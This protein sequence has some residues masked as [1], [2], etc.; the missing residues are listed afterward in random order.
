[1]HVAVYG[2]LRRGQS[3][4]SVLSRHNPTLLG[5]TVIHGYAMYNVGGFPAI[6]PDDEASTVVVELYDVT[7]DAL[8]GLDSLEGYRPGN[9]EMSLYLRQQIS[10]Q[11]IHPYIYVWNGSI[12]G[13]A[14]LS[15]DWL[16]RNERV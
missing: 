13:P 14:I 8:P 2:T 3:N 12:P 5:T 11:S 7:A 6:L 9:P 1:M 10:V 15:G 4:H 16:L